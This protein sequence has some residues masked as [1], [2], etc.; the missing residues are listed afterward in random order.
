MATAFVFASATGRRWALGA[1][2]AA[3]AIG[4]GCTTARMAVPEDLAT[5]PAQPVQGRQGWKLQEPIA[6]GH[7]RVVDVRR[8]WTRGSDLQVIVYE[9]SRRR[10]VY[11]FTLDEAGESQL[12]GD[13]EVT[14]QRR[15]V[16]VGVDI[17]FQHR[18]ALQGRLVP[19]GSNRDS[20][21]AGPFAESGWTVQLAETRD[22]PFAGTVSHGERVL[23]VAGIDRLEGSSLPLGA[24]SGYTLTYQGRAV[25]AV[26]TIGNG[27]VRMAPQ[28]DPDVRTVVAGVAAALLLFEELRHTLPE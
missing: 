15:A 23:Y 27:S 5:V 17:E 18:S 26:E 28:L 7:Y 4:A 16:D 11:R 13:F 6:F 3:V 9:S 14:L 24:T 2:L 1:A 19:V 22:R 21:V 25:A 10:Q 12:R 8:S 20:G